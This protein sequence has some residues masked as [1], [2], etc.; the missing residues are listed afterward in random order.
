MSISDQQDKSSVLKWIHLLSSPTMALTKNRERRNHSLF[1][2]SIAI[3]INQVGDTMFS[4]EPVSSEFI[5]NV[6]VDHLTRGN[7]E[8]TTFWQVEFASAQKLGILLP[9]TCICHGKSSHCDATRQPSLE[10]TLDDQFKLFLYIVKDTSRALK[11]P[12]DRILVASWVQ[13]L[14][15]INEKACIRAKGIR[16]DY[17]M[18]L[19]G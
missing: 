5:V 1:V 15:A 7:W 4:L 18:L 10:A 2:L 3:A 12:H 6:P 8:A 16:N 9:D 13:M 17:I 19:A 11:K 14:C